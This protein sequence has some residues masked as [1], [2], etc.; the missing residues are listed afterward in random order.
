MRKRQ[1][2]VLLVLGWYDYRL[3]CG[4]EKYAQEHR[5]H[6]SPKVTRERVIPWGWDG[7]GILA[8]LAEGDDLAEFVVRARKPTVDFS[9]R[10]PHLK[11][12]RVL[13][14]HAQSARLVAEHFLSRGFTHFIYYEDFDN[15]SF[16]ERGRA[17]VD[18]LNRAGKECRW[19]RWRR[20]ATSSPAGRYHEWK[21]KRKWLAAELINSPKPVAVF[22]PSDWMAVDILE[23]CESVALP[24]PEQVAI[25][26]ADNL[27]LAADTMRTPITTVDPNLEAMGY[28][29]AALLDELMDG[30]PPPKEPIRVPPVGLIV[31]KSSDLFAVNHEGVARSLR[32]MGK[33]Y[34]EPIGVSDLARVAA[35][36]LRGFHQAF[37]DHIGRSPG[38]E[39]QRVRIERAKELLTSSAEKTEIVAAKSGYQSVNSFW[40]AFRKATGMSPNQYRRKFSRHLES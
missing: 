34:H 17:F 27:L 19:L 12:P 13:Y 4:I 21:R 23:T 20:P 11:F 15:W 31:R 7:D 5:W 8:W 35:M 39:L 37:L 33:H 14:D 6:L 38:G 40:V 26:G 32:F 9:F 25:V 10:R 3:Q 16:E 36:S 2:R 1:R 29:G 22:A 28:Q 24:V 30:K 18:A